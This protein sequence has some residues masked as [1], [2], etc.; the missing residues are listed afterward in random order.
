M[1]SFIDGVDSSF[2]KISSSE[3]CKLVEVMIKLVN[4]MEFFFSR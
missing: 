3:F 2:K 1:V 4:F